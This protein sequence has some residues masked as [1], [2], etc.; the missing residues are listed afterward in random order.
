VV[1]ALELIEHPGHRVESPP[2]RSWRIDGHELAA[3]V[4]RF[5]PAVRVVDGTPQV[6]RSTAS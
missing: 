2:A 5:A 3:A 4:A 6:N 1:I